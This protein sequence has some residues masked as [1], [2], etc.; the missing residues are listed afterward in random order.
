MLINLPLMSLSMLDIFGIDA[1]T[2]I[3]PVLRINFSK[4]HTDNE[5]ILSMT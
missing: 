4:I 5:V 2:I 3:S 1:A